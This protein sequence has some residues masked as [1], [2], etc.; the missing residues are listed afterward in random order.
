MK[1]ILKVT[2]MK[3][4]G[5]ENHSKEELLKVKGVNNVTPSR[6]ENKIEVDCEDYVKREDLVKAINEN[7]H[8]HAE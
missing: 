6:K 4:E 5:C 8:F 1:I 3:C 2:G 7:T